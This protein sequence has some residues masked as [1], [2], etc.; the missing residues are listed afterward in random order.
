MPVMVGQA[1]SDYQIA[2]F[3]F[4]LFCECQNLQQNYDMSEEL[5][6]VKLNKAR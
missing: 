3:T 6:P 5:N 4:N 2:F 1:F